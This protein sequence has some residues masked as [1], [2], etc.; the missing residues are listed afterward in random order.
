MKVRT[1]ALLWALPV[2]LILSAII[3]TVIYMSRPGPSVYHI[4]SVIPAGGAI[5]VEAAGY[6]GSH[7]T[8]NPN[9][10][11]SV[12]IIYYD[13]R[14]LSAIGTYEATEAA[15]GTD[16]YKFIYTDCLALPSAGGGELR[17]Q[18]DYILRDNTARPFIY[19]AHKDQI[20]FQDPLGRVYI[21]VK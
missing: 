18:P 9:G 12:E 11:F 6:E 16:A 2:T 1:K 19:A 3:N 4:Q 15:G 17:P 20:H 5:P 7:L 10:T 21:F 8:L 13:T 14:G